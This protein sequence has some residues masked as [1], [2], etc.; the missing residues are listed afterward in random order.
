MTTEQAPRSRRRGAALEKAILEAVL[1]ELDDQGYRALTVEAVAARASASKAS[2]YR[3]WPT[4][5]QLV[6]A[7][8]R[9][10]IPDRVGTPDQG[11]LRADLLHLVSTMAAGF[12]GPLGEAMRGVVGD[13]LGGGDHLGA[14]SAG[15]SLAAVTAVVERAV[16]RGEVS[17]ERLVRPRLEA[18]VA[19]LRHQ[20]LMDRLDD[21][22]VTE[23]VDD[24]MLPLLLD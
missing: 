20:V 23:I 9:H 19:Y 4:K 16:A 3:R 11:S 5:P 18:G 2:I 7:A 22:L 8:V 21:A 24:V 1:A 13:A 15:T 14:L 10:T 17:P 6:L 12:R